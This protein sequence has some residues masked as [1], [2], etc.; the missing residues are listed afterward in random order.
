MLEFERRWWARQDL[1]L[2]PSRYER[3]ALTIELRAPPWC[4]R[5]DSNPHE[6]G[7]SDSNSLALPVPPRPQYAFFVIS[8]KL[9]SGQFSDCQP[10]VD[11][12][13]CSAA[14]DP[15]PRMKAPV[16]RFHACDKCATAVNQDE[17]HKP[18]AISCKARLAK[19]LNLS[20]GPRGCDLRSVFYEPSRSLAFPPKPI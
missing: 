8:T 17:G 14:S 19:V 18:P 1:N 11:C 16:S 5:R 12:K 4:G 10:N 20:R 3:P 15:Q 7:S 6:Q 9:C 13:K 2:Q